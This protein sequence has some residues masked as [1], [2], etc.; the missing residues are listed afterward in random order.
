MK[1]TLSLKYFKVFFIDRI[2]KKGKK[3]KKKRIYDIRTFSCYYYF[4]LYL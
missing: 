2:L 4:N 1:N 3:R